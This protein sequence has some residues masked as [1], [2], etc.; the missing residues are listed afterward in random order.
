VLANVGYAL[1]EEVMGLDTVELVL[2]IEDAFPVGQFQLNPGSRSAA[3]VNEMRPCFASY[4]Q[5]QVLNMPY[6]QN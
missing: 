5:K 6:R 2:E 3:W 4:D 1:A